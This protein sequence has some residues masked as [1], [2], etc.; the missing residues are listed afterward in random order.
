VN[1]PD[2]HLHTS[3][4]FVVV[5]DKCTREITFAYT[6]FHRS[7][8]L[9]PFEAE[10]FATEDAANALADKLSTKALKRERMRV[11]V[12]RVD[13]SIMEGGAL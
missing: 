2:S 3:R 8:Q 10:M 5:Q 13:F 7:I 4:W 1:P 9:C 11:R 12:V 6:A